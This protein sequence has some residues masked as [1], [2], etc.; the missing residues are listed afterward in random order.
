MNKK[1]VEHISK[2]AYIFLLILA[3][4][5]IIAA[6]VF[7]PMGMDLAANTCSACACILT[8]PVLARTIHAMRAGRK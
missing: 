8:V 4:A 6:M 7:G 5:A 1:T 3:A 2:G